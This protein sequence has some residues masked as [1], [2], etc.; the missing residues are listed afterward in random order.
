MQHNPNS[1]Y[2]MKEFGKLKRFLSINSN[3]HPNGFFLLSKIQLIDKLSEDARIHKARP[4]RSQRNQ[5]SLENVPVPK[6]LD[7]SQHRLYRGIIASL[8]YLAARTRPYLGVAGSMP[9]SCFNEP[10]SVHLFNANRMWRYLKGRKDK[11]S[12]LKPG[13]SKPTTAYAH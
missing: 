3:T 5:S 8:K 12:L 13:A 7:K 1:I 9:F 2:Y 10:T 11:D 6:P 4:L